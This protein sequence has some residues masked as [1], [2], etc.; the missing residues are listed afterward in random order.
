MI[1]KSAASAK[2]PASPFLTTAA[3][4]APNTMK[5]AA[6]LKAQEELPRKKAGQSALDTFI[7]TLIILCTAIAVV[8]SVISVC[9]RHWLVADRKLFGLWYFCT[10][11]HDRKPQC[12]TDFS[13]AE[14]DGLYTALVFV[15]IIA[16]FAV[17]L[18]MFGLEM[19]ITSQICVDAYSRRKW[20]YGSGL[21]LLAFFM[22]SVVVLVFAIVLWNFITLTGISLTYW[23]E[24]IAAF[25][26]FLNSISGLHMCSMTTSDNSVDQA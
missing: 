18:A 2:N 8:L 23:S 19:L 21:I 4:R 14:V 22:T 25:L 6:L 17:V 11:E 5:P 12:T 16:T 1:A 10:L 26:F 7:R 24:L 20:A 15:R 3:V 9:S 13:G